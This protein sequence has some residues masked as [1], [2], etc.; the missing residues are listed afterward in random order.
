[1]RIDAGDAKGAY[2]AG[3]EAMRLL[4]AYGGTVEGEA[5][6]HIGLRRGAPR[7]G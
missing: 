5:L 2:E 6:I 3:A 4:E 7:E 1:M